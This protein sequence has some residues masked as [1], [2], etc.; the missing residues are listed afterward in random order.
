MSID[1]RVCV[2]VNVH[3]KDAQSIPH[4]RGRIENVVEGEADVPCRLLLCLC[5]NVKLSGRFSPPCRCFAPDKIN[6]FCGHD[7]PLSP[8]HLE[9]KIPE[10]DGWSN[11]DRIASGIM[12]NG[13]GKK[14]VWFSQEC[15]GACAQWM[16]G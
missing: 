9:R 6:I 13:N 16:A 12:K 8:L 10:T 11:R 5:S 3:L 1:K 2:C 15:I 14:R 4:L 7:L